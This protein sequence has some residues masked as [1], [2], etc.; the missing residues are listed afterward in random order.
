M[1]FW[2][3][4]LRLHRCIRIVALIT[5]SILCTF[6]NRIF[7]VYAAA[8]AVSLENYAD[9]II[10]NTVFGTGRTTSTDSPG[11]L[12]EIF[13]PIGLTFD[14]TETYL[15]AT[16]NSGGGAIRKITASGVYDGKTVFPG[17]NFDTCQLIVAGATDYLYV[18]S[19]VHNVKRLDVRK[20]LSTKYSGE[21]IAGP[22]GGLTCSEYSSPFCYG[23][24]DGLS[25]YSRYNSIS[26]MAVLVD[27]NNVDKT[28][29]VADRSNNK[30]RQVDV[31]AANSALPF[32]SVT[33]ASSVD[34][35]ATRLQGLA[36]NSATSTLYAAVIAGV[37]SFSIPVGH[38]SKAIFAGQL[39]AATGGIRLLV[40][41]SLSC[42]ALY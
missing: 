35:K 37:Y 28:L 29:F 17:V 1:L 12:G 32:L 31:T 14:V 30:I 22:Q 40:L 8:A 19:A 34:L 20:E 10:I 42:V 3:T 13:Y 16:D 7:D 36:V 15:Y 6:N 39:S 38:T 11:L 2:H 21:V 41:S 33:F 23:D 24:A 9:P 4:T 25:T 18:S 27:S 26:A 5:T